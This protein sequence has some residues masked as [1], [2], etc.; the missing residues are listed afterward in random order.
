[1]TGLRSL[2]YTDIIETDTFTDSFAHPS[3]TDHPAVSVIDGVQTYHLHTTLFDTV[4]PDNDCYQDR[5]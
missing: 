4:E 5:A 1:M 2:H 3:I